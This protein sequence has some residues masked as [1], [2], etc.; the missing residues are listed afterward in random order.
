MKRLVFSRY[1]FTPEAIVAKM[2]KCEPELQ[3]VELD[4]PKG[5]N[6]VSFLPLCEAGAVRRLL[7]KPSPHLPTHTHREG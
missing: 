3:T 5:T 6:L 2:A 4:L 7:L 1:C